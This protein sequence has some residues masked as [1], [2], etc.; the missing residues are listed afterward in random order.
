MSG[1]T[2]GCS[3]GLSNPASEVLKGRLMQSSLFQSRFLLHSGKAAHG[4]RV[5]NILHFSS[6]A[7]AVSAD[8][9][10]I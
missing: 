8:Y 9:L 2:S 10:Q 6:F 3:S 4:D 1:L 5:Q 7:T